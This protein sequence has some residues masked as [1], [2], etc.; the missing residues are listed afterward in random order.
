[1]WLLTVVSLT[2]SRWAISRLAHVSVKSR[3]ARW[4]S[5]LCPSCLD[6]CMTGKEEPQRV[7]K[8]NREIAANADRIFE[9]IADPAQQPLWDGN[10]NL[11]EAAQGQRVPS[12]TYS[13]CG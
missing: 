4:V 11:K 12:V 13:P 7:V 9:L 6:K 10:D 1:M 5:D 8:A 2:W 3:E